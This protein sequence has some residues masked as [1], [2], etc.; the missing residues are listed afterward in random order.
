MF[1]SLRTAPVLALLLL[2]ACEQPSLLERLEA[3]GVLEIATVPGPLT[4]R[5]EPEGPGGLE[6]R[7]AGDFARS[8]G[9]EPVF[10]V[11]PTRI[12]ALRALQRGEVQM[13]A[14]AALPTVRDEKRFRLS[15]PWLE[16]PLVFATTMGATPIRDAQRPP[17]H[18]VS[19]PDASRPAER[20]ALMEP[21]FP[22]EIV[23]GRLREHLLAEV[24]RGE[25]RHTLVDRPLLEFWKARHPRLAAGVE[26]PGL[27]GYRWYFP[28]EHDDSL[29]QAADRFLQTR[30]ARDL[31][32]TELQRLEVRRKRDFVTLRD[33]WRHVETRLP[34][35]E[36]LFRQAA[37]DTGIDWRLLAAVAYQE[38]HWQPDAVSPTGVRGIMMLTREAARHQGVT[39]RLDPAQSIAGGARYL[40]W[41]EQRIPERIDEPDRLWLTLA[42][43]NIGYGHLEDARVLTQRAGGDPDRWEDVRK[44]LPLLSKKKYYTTVKHGR[45]RGGEPVIYVDNIR[46]YHRL[47]VEWDHQRQG[48]DCTA[49]DYPR[50]ALKNVRNNA[51]QLSANTP[52]HAEVR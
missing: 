48:L 2:T 11:Y 31:I 10:H 12:E 42:G 4:C 51:P 46:F 19:V 6:Y 26:L 22:I 13:A 50:L 45:A 37:S 20:L 9:L 40:L 41:M 49:E 44:H 33:F 8:L 35:F 43:Y 39:N 17:N 27:E 30:S 32:R 29:Q 28:G 21:P 5:L 34:K 15:R 25:R 47:L 52:P 7:L 14:P 3:R 38:S 16:I 24:E 18:P 23:P 1:R 36:A